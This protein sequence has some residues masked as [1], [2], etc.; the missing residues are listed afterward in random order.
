MR[1]PARIGLALLGA[2]IVA[3]GVLWF[4]HTHE[5]VDDTV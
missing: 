1:W 4:L 3:L 2:L 5:R